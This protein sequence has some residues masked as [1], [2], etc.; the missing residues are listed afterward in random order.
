M[1]K[2]NLLTAKYQK[3]NFGNNIFSRKFIYVFKN[4]AYDFFRNLFNQRLEDKKAKH[5]Y[6][7]KSKTEKVR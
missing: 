2:S 7:E 1:N 6:C 4:K 3:L 5:F